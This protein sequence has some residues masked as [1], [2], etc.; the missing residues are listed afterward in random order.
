[1]QFLTFIALVIILVF[2]LVT[3]TFYTIHTGHV[4]VTRTLGALDMEEKG[5]GL[6]FKLPFVTSV[7]KNV[8][9]EIDLDLVN[10]TPKAA[11]NLSMK[12]FDITIFYQV[13]P[14]QAAEMR[15][16]YASMPADNGFFYPG[17]TLILKTARGVAYD[18]IAGFNSLDIHKNR[19][20]VEQQI[21]DGLQDRLN[22]D[23]PGIFSVTRVVVRSAVTD[24]SIEKAIKLAVEQEKI[25]E[26]KA[27]KVEIA[28]KDAEI[29]IERAR[30]I[31]M[32]NDII[33]QSLTPEYLQHE[34]NKALTAAAENGN[35]LYVVPANMQGN[36]I[37]LPARVA[38]K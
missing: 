19:T 5:E 15:A 24:P 33:N 6:H 30:G 38:S 12:D 35:S 11:D 3:G 7:E 34:F 4:G 26:A 18:V 29:E 17:S 25:L 14:S 37:I 31:K 23:D 8:V 20:P 10:L 2:S 13:D 36:G 28:K 1:M 22:A 32:A 16:K 27:M 21:K 9:K